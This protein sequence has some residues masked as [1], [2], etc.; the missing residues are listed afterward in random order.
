MSEIQHPLDN[1][2]SID[3]DNKS[4][5]F[6]CAT[7]TDPSDATTDPSD[8]SVRAEDLAESSS[9]KSD[10]GIVD[11]PS[12][13][14][15]QPTNGAHADANDDATNEN[16]DASQHDTVAGHAERTSITS[17]E[18]VS[19]SES[20]RL[21]QDVESLRAELDSE[22]S[23]HEETVMRLRQQFNSAVKEKD[24]VVMKFVLKENQILDAK[25]AQ[26]KAEKRVREVQN[27]AETMKKKMSKAQQEKDKLQAAMEKKLVEVGGLRRD[28]DKNRLEAKEKDD[29]IKW[30]QD[31]LGYEME[32][33]AK[34]KTM[35]DSVSSQLATKSEQLE[36]FGKVYME[37]IEAL[38][39]GVEGQD[40]NNLDGAAD[41][42]AGDRVR[43]KMLE[44]DELLE[45]AD[46]RVK[47]CEHSVAELG[48]LKKVHAEK[49]EEIDML[50]AKLECV[51]AE[52][53]SRDI[54]TGKLTETL[55][56][57][58]RDLVEMKELRRDNAELKEKL[59]NAQVSN[60]Q[61]EQLLA[62]VR[63]EL[64]DFKSDSTKTVSRHNELMEYVER[65]TAKSVEMQ[66]E[67]CTLKA[68]LNGKSEQLAAIELQ[69]ANISAEH[70]QLLARCEDEAGAR[71][72]ATDDLAEKAA[73]FEVCSPYFYHKRLSI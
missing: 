66:A 50:S 17:S 30:L 68:D 18:Q 19:E 7:T 23:S 47:E 31:R 9:P 61:L 51:S 28:V 46:R 40:A 20:Q 72:L 2:T 29:R 8:S 6:D 34:L 27:E 21:R 65:V 3:N 14:S 43:A 5:N 15:D 53:D 62:D 57:Q 35:N 42:G 45:D 54:N 48:S 59:S 41:K 67:L 36:R 73:K 22:R 10:M 1:R 70:D 26:L 32:Q 16:D 33:H 63:S 64:T 58:K 49:L 4:T 56:V 71:A 39:C 12:K 69:Y 11:T 38:Q 37:V 44:I 24:G 25:S 60:M 52:L 55:N 13:E